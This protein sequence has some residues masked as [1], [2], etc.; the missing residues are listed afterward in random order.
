[1]IFLFI[2]A[3]ICLLSLNHFKQAFLTFLIFKVYLVTNIC[4]LA[5]PGVPMLSLDV[6]MTLWFFFWI[7]KKRKNLSF[8]QQPIPYG[9]CFN[10]LAITYFISSLFSVAGLGAEISAY[11]KEMCEVVITPW[12]IWKVVETDDDFRFLFNGLAIAFLT[13]CI[14]AVYEKSI[15]ANPLVLYEA[16]LV[17]DSS[18]AINFTYE[19]EE[20]RGYRV[21]SVFEHAIGAGINWA[22]FS[23][24]TLG[25]YLNG[26]F[27]NS[28]AWKA[29]GICTA[30]FSLVCITFTNSRGP[31]LFALISLIGIFNLKKTK[32]Y[33]YIIAAII[34]T[35]ILIFSST[36]FENLFFSIFDSS[37]QSKVGGSD[38]DMRLNQL[39]SVFSL[40]QISPISG[41]GFKFLNVISNSDTRALLGLESMWFRIL[42][43]F[44]VLGT[45]ANIY[46]AHRSLIK[47]PPKYKSLNVFWISAAYWITASLTSVP[48]MLS[49]LYFL[50]I[51][52]WIK[53]SSLY[54]EQRR[55]EST[56][57]S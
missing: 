35:L 41:L 3:L 50:I 7:Y 47:I 55:Y 45:L 33:K 31:I 26:G 19:I 53:Q 25:C 15:Q 51:F 38:A 23:F 57:R 17:G 37:Y 16:S 22:M 44:G 30:I 40:M 10:F 2:G 8:N 1:M 46:Y 4:I 54:K 43:Q 36:V 6:G 18:R 27:K 32:H 20:L 28:L 24:L 52:Y 39:E 29:I 21:Q 12:M 14:Y 11:A 34:F 49:Y 42:V 48:G 56:I 9:K 5:I 13:T